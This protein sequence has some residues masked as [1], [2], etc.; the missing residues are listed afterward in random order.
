MISFMG[1]ERSVGIGENLYDA[2]DMK[3]V[4]LWKRWS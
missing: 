4:K 1:D 3:V 2:A